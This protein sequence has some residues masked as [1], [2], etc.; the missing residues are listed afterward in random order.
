MADAGA[1]AHSIRTGGR[2]GVAATA[3]WNRLATTSVP[4]RRLARSPSTASARRRKGACRTTARRTGSVRAARADASTGGRRPGPR[5][6]DRCGP[7]CPASARRHA[8]V[9][10]TPEPEQWASAGLRPSVR[11]TLKTLVEL[12]ERPVPLDPFEPLVSLFGARRGPCATVAARRTGWI[13]LLALA[14]LSPAAWI[15]R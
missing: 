12:D 7:G 13:P 1:T 10:P 15:W 5:R 9:P 2:R 14:D 8:G 6:H 4:R 3:G 11:S